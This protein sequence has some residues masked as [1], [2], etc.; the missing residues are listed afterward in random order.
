MAITKKA[1]TYDV[2]VT[3]AKQFDNGSIVF[4]MVV[5]GIT[6]Y[7]CNYVEGEKNGKKYSFTSFPSRK[8]NDGKYYNYVY[9][10]ISEYMQLDIEKQIEKLL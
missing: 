4:D 10:P 7:N 3:R 6:V 8:G 9:F 5:N 1:E 2:N